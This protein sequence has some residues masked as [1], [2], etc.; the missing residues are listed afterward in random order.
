ME[1]LFSHSGALANR[2][3]ELLD[4]AV[5]L[6]DCDGGLLNR[7]DGM[8]NQN[9]GVLKRLLDRDGMP[10]NHSGEQLNHDRRLLI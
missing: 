3:A 7:G 4:Q 5:E 8:L 1:K 2:E 10:P 9:V 6:L